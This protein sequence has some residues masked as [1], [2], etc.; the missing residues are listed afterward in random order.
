MMNAANEV[1]VASFLDDS[2]GYLDIA[3]CVEAAMDAHEKD[4]VQ[5]VESIAQLEE[6]DRWARGVARLWVQEHGR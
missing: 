1:A 4:G 5:R 3:S 2:I 6:L